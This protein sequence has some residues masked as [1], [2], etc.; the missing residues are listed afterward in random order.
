MPAFPHL[1]FI[2]KITGKPRLFGGGDSD[3]RSKTNKSNRGAHSQYLTDS[4]DRLFED[5]QETLLEREGEGLPELPQ[6][7]IPVFL[8]IDPNAVGYGLD[9]NAFGIEIISEEEDGYILGASMDSLRTLRQKI[10]DF[11]VEKYGSGGIAELWE[12]IS[13]N[14]ESWIP[15]RILTPELLAEWQNIDDAGKYKVEISIAFDR[16][17]GKRPDPTKQGGVRRLARYEANEKERDERLMERETSFENFI[18]QYGNFDSG[19]IHLEDCFGAEVTISGVGLKDLVFNYPFVFEVGFAEEFQLTEIEEQLDFDANFEVV[20]PAND[21]PEIGVI[22][23]GIMQGHRYLAPAIRTQHSKCY[24][25]GTTSVVDEVK[26]GGH[27]TR[28]AG[29][30]LYPRGV[31]GVITPYQLPCFVRNL[32]ILDGNS[33]LVTKYPAEV[34]IKIVEQNQDCKIFNH[35]INSTKPFR[36]KHMSAWAATI[37]TLIHTND[38]L[39]VISSGN[40]SLGIVR[41]FLANGRVYPDYLNDG[42]CRIANPG[43]SS[44]ALTVGSVNHADFEDADWIGLGGNERISAF[45]RIGM[46]IWNHIK[47]DV[48]EFGGGLIADK[49]S[50][51]LVRYNEQTCTETIR[52]TD[53]GGN[54]F[55]KD[56]VGT[57]FAAPRVTSIVA[58]LKKLYPTENSNLLRALVVQ[59]ARLPGDAFFTPSLESI[60]HFGYGLPSLERVT[61]NAE[62]RISYYNTGELCAEEAHLYNL[63]IP[64][65][66]RNPADEYDILIEVTLAFTAKVRRTRQRTNS[67]LG[68]WLDWTSSKKDETYQSF[69]DYV[70]KEVNGESTE[71][72]KDTRN[73]MEGFGWKIRERS[74]QGAIEGISRNSSSLQKDWAIL[75]AYEMPKDLSFAVRAHKGWDKSFASI[76]YAIVVSIEFLGSNLPVYEL[77]QTENESEQQV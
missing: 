10:S 27:G 2:Q 57:S 35:S 58:E 61:R 59:G 65:Q 71:Y 64:E 72:D 34:L 8:Q 21:S 46:G 39:F 77:I 32:R 3:E 19:I 76:P 69:R 25:P 14:R 4:A 20:A 17:L 41:Y 13:G 75:K 52:S 74:D 43:Q 6:D 23:S 67:Y 38:V 53:G 44:F 33:Q 37:D 11:D 1:N 28:V 9:L 24:I 63:K 56:A 15:E 22:D 7:V 48:V 36:L 16:P 42:F 49:A 47:P 50:S 54:A 68:T 12:I 62:Q 51:K 45:S 66:L 26:D 73:A 5:W 40:I 18:N 70:M 55:A 29:A 30:I 60:K 31:T